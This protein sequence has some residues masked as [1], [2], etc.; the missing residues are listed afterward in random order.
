MNRNVII[1]GVVGL[2]LVLGAGWYFASPAMALSQLRQAAIDG[3]AEQLEESID[4]P[5][6]RE[7]LKAEL[8]ATMAAELARQQEAGE[9]GFG[10]LGSAIAMGMVDPMVDGFVNPQSMAS[11]IEKGKMDRMRAGEPGDNS[12]TE[13]SAEPTDWEISRDGFSRFTAT[14]VTPEGERVPT[15]VF[16]R[17]GLGW[18]LTAIDLPEG[19]LNAD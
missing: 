4:F 15:M 9:D 6:V 14:P 3:D 5:A 1:A 10:M 11:M 8:R 17:D 13:G 7:S 12:E 16:E 19:P 18:K 2:V